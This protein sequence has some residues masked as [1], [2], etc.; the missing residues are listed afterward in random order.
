M[1]Q[2]SSA[3]IELQR[4]CDNQTVK[5]G[6]WVLLVVLLSAWP[7]LQWPCCPTDGSQHQNHDR[8]TF[9]AGDLGQKFYHWRSVL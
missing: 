1:M 2:L 5:V 7:L 6:S 8:H 9:I 3:V 4:R